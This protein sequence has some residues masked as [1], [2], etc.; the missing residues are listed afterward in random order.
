MFDR[1]PERYQAVDMF[2]V[3][4]QEIDVDLLLSSILA[5]VIEDPCPG[6]IL[7][8]RK[9]VFR[10]P[11]KMQPDFYPRHSG[12]SF[13]LLQA[14]PAYFKEQPYVLKISKNVFG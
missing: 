3:S 13:R 6:S 7:E 9:P 5:D 14:N 11:N 2:N 1:T 8:I 10:T 4:I 12:S